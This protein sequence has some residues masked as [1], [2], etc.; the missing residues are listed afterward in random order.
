M[1]ERGAKQVTVT[2][3]NDKRQIT[4]L[5][6]VTMAGKLLPPQVIYAGLT[7]RC[8]PRGVDFPADWM[9]TY[10]ANHWSNGESM[11]EYVDSVLVPYVKKQR[12][13]RRKPKQKALLVLDVFAAHRTKPFLDKLKANNILVVF[14]PACCTD[15]LQPLDLTL[16]KEYKDELKACFHDWYSREVQDMMDRKKEESGEDSESVGEVVVD[17]RLSTLKPMLIHTHTQQAGREIRADQA[18]LCG[19]WPLSAC[20]DCTIWKDK[21]QLT[22]AQVGVA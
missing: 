13:E 4:L 20:V 16:N 22:L 5:L 11:L 1:A 9:T 21:E 6:S 19:G 14:V 17:L 3:I 8:L 12:K 10:T 2:G 18:G 15:K 7:D